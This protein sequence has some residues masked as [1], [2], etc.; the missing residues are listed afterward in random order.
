MIYFLLFLQQSIASM[1]HI[2]GK[3]AVESL[4]PPLVLTFRAAIASV[5]LV[6]FVMIKERRINLLK[7]IATKDILRLVILGILNIPFNQFLYLE[8]LKYTTPAN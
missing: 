1:T 3:D 2:I 7:G 8:G 5:A 4:S 6:S